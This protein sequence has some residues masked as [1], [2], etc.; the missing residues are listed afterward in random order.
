MVILDGHQFSICLRARCLRPWS[1]DRWPPFRLAHTLL[2][3]LTSKPLLA[4]W[5]LHEHHNI[6]FLVALLTFYNR[7][8]PLWCI[9]ALF[10]SLMSHG[11]ID[12]SSSLFFCC[13][14]IIFHHTSLLISFVLSFVFVIVFFSMSWV[15]IFHISVHREH[16]CP[17]QLL[18]HGHWFKDH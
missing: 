11:L 4:L 10:G 18:S 15:M 14:T 12:S 6:F 5:A 9:Y 7:I 13:P 16:S 3:L 1:Q 2:P 17:H 8:R